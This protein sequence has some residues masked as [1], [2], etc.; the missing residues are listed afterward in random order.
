MYS[1]KKYT[2]VKA[3]DTDLVFLTDFYVANPRGN[4]HQIKMDKKKL[5]RKENSKEMNV[6]HDK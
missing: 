2:N 3:L 5:G 1:S 4:S 6:R